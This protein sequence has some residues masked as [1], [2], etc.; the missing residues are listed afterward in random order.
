MASSALRHLTSLHCTAGFFLILTQ[1]VQ[2]LLSYFS[3]VVSFFSGSAFDSQGSPFSLAINFLQLSLSILLFSTY[4]LCLCLH[5]TRFQLNFP[6]YFWIK[7]WYNLSCYFISTPQ[8][9]VR[10]VVR[11]KKVWWHTIRRQHSTEITQNAWLLAGALSAVRGCQCCD[12]PIP[13]CPTL[14]P[15]K[16]I[17]GDQTAQLV[18][19][20]FT[21]GETQE[22]LAGC[23]ITMCHSAV[24]VFVTHFYTW[25][26][27]QISYTR[28][29][30]V[31]A[32]VCLGV[33]T[34]GLFV[35]KL[36]Q[37]CIP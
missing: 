36:K 14:A 10:F 9:Q 12:K 7:G 37:R 1:S 28:V 24:T 8:Q 5:V 19:I 31:H 16:L 22:L 27:K 15:L 11:C 34:Q 33:D 13:M 2:G 25:I 30:L 21:F 35:D 6:L 29:S 17:T 4:W 3:M 32:C 23:T 20:L 26:H 18:N